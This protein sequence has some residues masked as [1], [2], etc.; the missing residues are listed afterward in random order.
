MHRFELEQR[1]REDNPNSISKLTEKY[2]INW[3]HVS[4][5]PSHFC[6]SF[7]LNHESDAFRVCHVSSLHACVSSLHACPFSSLRAFFSSHFHHP[8]LHHYFFLS[9]WAELHPTSQAK[10]LHQHSLCLE[11]S[12]MPPNYWVFC[13]HQKEFRNR[14]MLTLLKKQSQKFKRH[15]PMQN[16]NITARPFI[17]Q[18]MSLQRMCHG[19]KTRPSR[20]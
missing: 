7:S 16:R 2:W 12:S 4:S 13:D 9:L 20:L 5:F 8:K 18:T 10:Y 3:N 14:M 19:R 1:A 6:V 11:E 17:M 15:A